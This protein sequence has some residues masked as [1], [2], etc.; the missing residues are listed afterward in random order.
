M[1]MPTIL[2]VNQC[3]IYTVET[4]TGIYSLAGW[5]AYNKLSTVYY[6]EIAL[7][8]NS[9]QHVDA[10]NARVRDD[11][12]CEKFFDWDHKRLL[13]LDETELVEHILDLERRF[14]GITPLDA[15]RFAFELAE[16]LQLDHP[17]NKTAKLAGNDWLSGFK[18]EI[19]NF[20]SELQSLLA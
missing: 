18:K 11:K 17:F 12:D 13:F 16:H 7:N 1:R 9:E 8:S 2:D 20:L 6:C 3:L 19:L 10:A 15:R 4:L 5:V 14:Y